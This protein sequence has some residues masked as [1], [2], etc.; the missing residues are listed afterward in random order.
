MRLVPVTYDGYVA[1]PVLRAVGTATRQTRAPRRE[2]S[3][4]NLSVTF[5]QSRV[6]HCALAWSG[7]SAAPTGGPPP[8]PKRSEI[9]TAL[10]HRPKARRRGFTEKKAAHSAT[11]TLPPPICDFI[12]SSGW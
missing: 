11:V 3:T 12:S 4:Q 10:R 9:Y 2:N 6:T 8:G 7:Y 5:S 1:V